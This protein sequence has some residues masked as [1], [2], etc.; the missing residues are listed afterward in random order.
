[1]SRIELISSLQVDANKW[2]ITIAA[3]KG[4]I[5][6]RYEYL[7]HLCKKWD[8][9]VV[10]D[11]RAIMPLP[12]NKKWGLKYYYHPAF[13]QRLGITGYVS[14]TEI[15][16]IV[17]LIKANSWIAQI[18]YEA[19]KRII[20]K[21]EASQ[22]ATNFTLNIDRPFD[23]VSSRLSKSFVSELKK[24]N[25]YDIKYDES[26]ANAVIDMWFEEYSSKT[27]IRKNQIEDFRKL[28]N[29]LVKEGN[30]YVRTV[31]YD[32]AVIAAAIL[33]KDEFRLY[34]ILN[35]VSET[36]RKISANYHLYYEILK[37][38]S[39]RG[40]LFDFEGSEL[41]GVKKFYLKFN[42]SVE[43]Y[44]KTRLNFFPFPLS[45]FI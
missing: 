16:Q 21:N 23:V 40:L 42:P 20:Y 17:E 32:N 28:C 36:G 4:L 25:R 41:P 31:V 33:F 6:S 24:S 1:V 19:D 13:I 22:R 37:E 38:F 11:Y 39:G 2:N 35:S 12:L 15:D 10:D 14:P 34:N 5:Y 30:C 26:D 44:Y 29:T 45:Y 9:I 18:T 8:G 27:K 7:S 3:N 43:N